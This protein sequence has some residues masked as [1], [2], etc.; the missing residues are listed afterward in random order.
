[1]PKLCANN[2]LVVQQESVLEMLLWNK[3]LEFIN[4]N[5]PLNIF[6]GLITEFDFQIESYIIHFLTTYWNRF[7]SFCFRTMQW[8]GTNFSWNWIGSKNGKS[9]ILWWR[10][11][12]YQHKAFNWHCD[13][14]RNPE[15][16]GTG[17]YGWIC[18]HNQNFSED[19]TYALQLPHHVLLWGVDS[20][21]VCI[22]S[23]LSRAGQ[24]R[25]LR[26]RE[27]PI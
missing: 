18:F 7:G 8:V 19:E 12:L 14:R 1:M 22:F 17:R 11:G 5:F 6:L 15:L 26:P 21:W 9:K 2:S 13:H 3:I 25:F 16:T 24:P 20:F 27:S 23:A 10:I 4:K